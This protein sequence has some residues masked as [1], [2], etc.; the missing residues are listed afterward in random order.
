MHGTYCLQVLG[1]DENKRERSIR[2]NVSS[3]TGAHIS[4]YEAKRG[5]TM[6]KVHTPS[7]EI[8][9]DRTRMMQELGWCEDDL[10][11]LLIKIEEFKMMLLKTFDKHCDTISYTLKYNSLYQMS[12][13]IERPGTQS[14]PDKN[15]CGQINELFQQA[16]RGSF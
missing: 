6:T 1:Y 10:S 4:E 11:A 12:E 7:S 9:S 13:N 16:F 2:R 8:V 15:Q 14:V 3:R 5:S